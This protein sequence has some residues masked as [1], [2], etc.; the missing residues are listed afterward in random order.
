[1]PS[2]SRRL[3]ACTG[4]SE[5][6]W[7]HPLLSLLERRSSGFLARNVNKFGHSGLFRRNRKEDTYARQGSQQRF[8]GRREWK[9]IHGPVGARAGGLGRAG[10]SANLR[11]GGGRQPVED[12]QEV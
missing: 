5:R 2:S 4:R 10:G 8:L 6:G 12:R 3:S 9:L 11:R 7:A 1:W